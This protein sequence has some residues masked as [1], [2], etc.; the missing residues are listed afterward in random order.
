MLNWLNA[1]ASIR[2]WTIINEFYLRLGNISRISYQIEV[3][4]EVGRIGRLSFVNEPFGIGSKFLLLRKISPMS[5]SHPGWVIAYLWH[6]L[7]WKFCDFYLKSLNELFDQEWY[8]SEK[9]ICVGSKCRNDT[10]VAWR[11]TNLTQQVRMFHSKIDLK[12]EWE[13]MLMQYPIPLSI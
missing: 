2:S 3:W 5:S 9:K 13:D 8:Q 11:Y 12:K 4:S 7:G 6:K 10:Q 1:S